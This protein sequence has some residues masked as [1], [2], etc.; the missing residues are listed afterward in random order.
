MNRPRIYTASKVHRA[1]MWRQLRK[2]Y[3][4]WLNLISTWIN[5]DI[6]PMMESDA[7]TCERGWIKNITEA[8]DC[9]WL[10]CYAEKDDPLS[11]TLVEI[12]AALGSGATVYILGDCSRYSTWRHHPFVEHLTTIHPS[13]T[14]IDAVRAALDRI[15]LRTVM[16]RTQSND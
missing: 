13:T 3:S 4:P 1:P 2:E 10:V 14:P 8:G 12:G 16:Q 9:N 7:E 15:V 5:E 11:G 6:T